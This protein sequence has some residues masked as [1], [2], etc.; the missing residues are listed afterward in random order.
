MLRALVAAGALTV[1]AVGA[2]APASAYHGGCYTDA[3]GNCY[4]APLSLATALPSPADRAAYGTTNDQ[5]FAYYVTHDDDAPEFRIVDFPSLKGQALW[6]CQSQTNG[7]RSLDVIYALQRASGYTFDQANNIH[8]SA[9]TIY[10]PWNS[11][12]PAPPPPP[13]PPLD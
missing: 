9:V 8:A 12:A 6:A 13:P 7:M 11:S 5:R 3:Y 2:A 10:C 1:A 4:Y